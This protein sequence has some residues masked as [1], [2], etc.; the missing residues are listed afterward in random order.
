MSTTSAIEDIAE[1]YNVKVIR[2]AVGEINVINEMKKNNSLIGGEGNGG[3]ILSESHYGRDALV[4]TALLLNRL[5][6]EDI[7]ASQLYNKVP[8]YQ[9]IKDFIKTDKSLDQSFIKSIKEK[10]QP[11][12]INEIDGIK[13]IWPNKWIHVRKSNTEPIVRFYSEAEVIKDS[14]E[15]I[16]QAKK[17]FKN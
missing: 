7:T 6:K 1:K 15:L 2:S 3:V 10:F 13:L 4:A 11:V 5:S 16:N 9:I 8:H 17:I 14:N 12:E